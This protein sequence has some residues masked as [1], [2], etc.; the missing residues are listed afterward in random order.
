MTDLVFPCPKHKVIQRSASELG[1]SNTS[2]VPKGIKVSTSLGGKGVGV[3]AISSPGDDGV[4]AE[5]QIKDP[6]VCNAYM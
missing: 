6:K 4:I 3:F 5:D 1:V 2:E